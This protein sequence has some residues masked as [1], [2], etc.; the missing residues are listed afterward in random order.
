MLLEGKSYR[1]HGPQKIFLGWNPK[2]DPKG[3]WLAWFHGDV[4]ELLNKLVTHFCIFS[5]VFTVLQ[6]VVCFFKSQMSFFF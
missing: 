6:G 4:L 5:H 3:F 2:P 1:L